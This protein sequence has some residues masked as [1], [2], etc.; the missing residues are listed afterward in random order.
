MARLRDAVSKATTLAPG[1]I[2]ITLS[3]THG[4][5]WMSRSRSELPGGDLIGPYLDDLAVKL[6]N[7]ATQAKQS[8]QQA[9]IVYGAGR[10][11][12]TAQRDYF[13]QD[14]KH[15]VCGFNPEAFADDT[16][17][18][19]RITNADGIRLATIVNYACHPTTLAWENTAISPDYV[20]AM[21]EVIEQTTGA[22]CL[23]MQGASG[24]LGP[25]EGFVGDHAIADKNGRQLGYAA[26]SAL[27]ALPPPGTRFV[28]TGRVLSGATLGTWQHQALDA[29]AIMKGETWIVRPWTVDLP[30]RHDLPTLEETKKAH[31]HWSR[32]EATAHASGDAQKARDCRAMV[33]QMNRRLHRLNSLPVGRVFPYRVNLWRLGDAFWLLCRRIVQ[34]RRSRASD[35]RSVR[36]G[37]AQRRLQ[38]VFAGGTAYGHEF[39]RKRLRR[40]AGGETLI[41]AI[42]MKLRLIE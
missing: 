25:R 26:M 37:D 20:G 8:V 9:T 10:C 17:L 3:H 41:E 14:S 11:A 31:E 15:F 16:L 32:E 18:I 7:L 28:Y 38:P 33:E 2:Q 19:A 12:L 4:S 1:Q 34:T 29:A 24:D 39:I 5:G 27:E 21:R 23:F 42:A 35:L 40:A 36:R 13:D 6:A 30:Y 22:P